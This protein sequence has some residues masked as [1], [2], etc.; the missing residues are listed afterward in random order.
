MGTDG[1]QALQDD[2]LGDGWV[3]LAEAAGLLGVSVDTIRRRL[4]KGAFEAQQVPTQHGPAWMVRLGDVPT[5]LPT[6]SSTPRQDAASLELVH[7]VRD[8]QAELLRR[9]EAAAMWQARAE[10]LGHQLRALE[11]PRPHQTATDARET[12]E[13]PDPPS[14][15]PDPPPAPS[16]APAPIPPQPNGGSP[17]W[18]RW[19]VA[20]TGV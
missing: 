13:S 11:A 15:P 12:A 19:W 3:T 20:I 5:V 4:R 18:R 16:P 2:A 1:Q 10:M 7:L 14:E 8:L 6:G 9:S 17:W